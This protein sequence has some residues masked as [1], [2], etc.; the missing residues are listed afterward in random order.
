MIVQCS[1]LGFRGLET[2]IV[3]KWSIEPYTSH[4]EWQHLIINI[5]L[6]YTFEELM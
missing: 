6:T 2:L 5:L 3:Y 4:L 1:C